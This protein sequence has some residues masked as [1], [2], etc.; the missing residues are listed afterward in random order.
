MTGKHVVVT[1]AGTGIGRAIAVRLAREGASL[2]LPGSGSWPARTA[3]SL[4]AVGIG[5]LAVASALLRWRLW[6]V[7]RALPV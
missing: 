4:V 2:T 7:D 3:V 6:I 1:G 5:V